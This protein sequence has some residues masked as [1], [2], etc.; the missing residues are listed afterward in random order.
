MPRP[1]G[2]D[3]QDPHWVADMALC[4]RLREFQRQAQQTYSDSLKGDLSKRH[5]GRH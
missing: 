3:D 4:L 1:G 5:G 2:L